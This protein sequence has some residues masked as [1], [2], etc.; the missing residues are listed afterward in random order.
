[1]VEVVRQI[2]E[3][4]VEGGKTERNISEDP[5]HDRK[6]IAPPFQMNQFNH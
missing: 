5:A 6:L 1:M 4:F 2:Y 3:L